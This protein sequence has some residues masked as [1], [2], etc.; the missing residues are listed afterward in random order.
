MSDP[1]AI[2]YLPVGNHHIAYTR[3]LTSVIPSH[4][5]I[6]FLSGFRS[7]MFG[8]KAQQLN[9]WAIHHGWSV[10]RFD[11][12]GHG[13]SSGNFSDFTLQDWLH[14]AESVMRHCFGN[15][16]VMLIGSS[17]GGWLSYHLAMQHP[18]Q[19]HSL[20]TIASAP[21]FITRLFSNGMTDTERSI[22]KT[23]GKVSIPKYSDRALTQAFFDTGKAL[24]IL[25]RETLPIH[26]PVYALH[27]L[28][29]NVAPWENSVAIAKKITSST[30][31]VE[32][33]K[34]GDHRLSR[35]S[36]LQRLFFAIQRMADQ[37]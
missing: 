26:C 21:D 12:R 35:Q 32:L 5:N 31:S 4:L 1:S 7:S 15:E 22:L 27:G 20:I 18:E 37:L 11:Y 19:V 14:D 8:N 9:D 16:P 24:A 2:H 17:M 28:G 29:D 6:L 10:A 13:E 25:N 33:I 3:S 36:D 30:S 34:D 23:T